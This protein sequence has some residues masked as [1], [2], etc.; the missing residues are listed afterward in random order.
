MP[1]TVAARDFV[2]ARAIEKVAGEGAQ[3]GAVEIALVVERHAVPAGRG[4][5]PIADVADGIGFAIAPG[6]DI[7][8]HEF[9][10]NALALDGRDVVVLDAQ[11]DGALYVALESE[12]DI[13]SGQ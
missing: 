1:A 3:F 6:R 10:I 11:G 2:R 4:I 13:A 7:A 12:V 9:G 8:A 5:Q